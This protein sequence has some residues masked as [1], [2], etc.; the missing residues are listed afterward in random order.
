MDRGSRETANPAPF[1][2]AP[3]QPPGTPLACPS[4]PW[5]TFTKMFP[6]TATTAGYS[7]HDGAVLAGELPPRK[8]KLVV[9]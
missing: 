5:E 8:H 2:L 3:V 1:V 6:D 4:V 7:I 9:A